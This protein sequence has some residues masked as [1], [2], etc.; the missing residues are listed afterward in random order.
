[1]LAEAA[2]TLRRWAAVAEAAWRGGEDIAAALDAAFAGDLTG[3]DPVHREKLET[4]NGVHS[5]A[6]GLPALARHPG[7]GH[8]GHPHDLA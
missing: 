5:N 7:R 4:L 2:E 1:M 3:V 6:A 8:G